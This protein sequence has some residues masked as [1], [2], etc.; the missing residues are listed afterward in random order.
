MKDCSVQVGLSLTMCSR[1]LVPL[2]LT[3][4][5]SGQPI[6]VLWHSSFLWLNFQMFTWQAQG[7]NGCNKQDTFTILLTTIIL[8]VYVCENKSRSHSWSERTESGWIEGGA[9][10]RCSSFPLAGCTDIPE[11][12]YLLQHKYSKCNPRVATRSTFQ[13]ALG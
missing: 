7:H 6:G 13:W 8:L 12:F 9:V 4:V 2:S 11:A 3:S 1:K 5:T 10:T